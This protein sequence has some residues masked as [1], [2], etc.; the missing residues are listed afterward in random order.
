MF[1][2][3]LSLTK[4]GMVRG[5]MILAATGFLLASGK[6]INFT[7]FLLTVVGVSC[8]VASGCV[9]NNYIDREID[10]KMLRT[11]SRAFALEKVKTTNTLLFATIFA[12][13]GFV[14]LFFFTN[15]VTLAVTLFGLVVYVGI[16]SPLK[17]RSSHAALVGSL[18]GGVPIVAGYTAVMHSINGAALLLFFILV[19]WQMPH[20]YSIALYRY[21]EYK[22]AGVP[23]FPLAKGVFITKIHILAY[24]SAFI[25]ATLF[26]T[27]F[28][29]A[30]Y[31]YAG[32]AGVLG[33]AWF[34]YGLRGLIA[35]TDTVK[36]SRTMFFIS[37]AVLMVLC[38]VLSLNAFL[39]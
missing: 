11:K 1:K 13:I 12:A 34:I 22:A 6:H 4:P 26:L 20:F 19:L 3:Y 39:I 35:K 15:A 30:G 23:V 17:H 14:V 38:S 33:V 5:N 28:G 21:E 32:V 36:W 7:L 37:L 29:Y 2:T 25:T 10:K 24:I 8:V 31:I 27:V 16:Y 9:F 18:A